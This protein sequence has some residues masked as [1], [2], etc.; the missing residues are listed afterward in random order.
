MA[1]VESAPACGACDPGGNG[2]IDSC[3]TCPPDFDGDGDVD[4]A[5]LA[6]LL[7]AWGSCPDGCQEDLNFDCEV[8]AADLA[9]LL[10]CWGTCP[11]SSQQAQWNGGPGKLGALRFALGGGDGCL[12][13]EEAVQMMGHDDVGAFIEWVLSEVP[14]DWVHRVAQF[15]LW[16]LDNWPC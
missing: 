7:G 13:L 6:E 15:L 4:A 8:D 11:C 14:P 1:L 9:I 12:S 10:G 3:E 2:I 5:D 16:L